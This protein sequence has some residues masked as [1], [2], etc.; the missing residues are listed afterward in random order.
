MRHVTVSRSKK[1]SHSTHTRVHKYTSRNTF[2]HIH[3]YLYI[4]WLLNY[5]VNVC[6]CC[7]APCEY[8]LM[9]SAWMYYGI[10]TEQC[11]VWQSW[12]W[13]HKKMSEEQAS[14]TNKETICHRF[15]PGERSELYQWLW[16][17]AELSMNPIQP[18]PFSLATVCFPQMLSFLS[19]FQLHLLILGGAVHSCSLDRSAF[20]LLEPC[21]NVPVFGLKTLTKTHSHTCI[22]LLFPAWFCL[23]K[24][25]SDHW[26]E[27][28]PM[29]LFE[30]DI[31]GFIDLF[32]LVLVHSWMHLNT[33]KLF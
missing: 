14:I 9:I 11:L 33:C 20:C 24:H 26:S 32:I 1:C 2:L 25:I 15:G 23:T 3:H 18:V 6:Y 12:N 21:G 8:I 22:S 4:N 29:L 30:A 13:R 31:K 16:V 5:I 7:V 17:A 19:R 27:S 28:K 10:K